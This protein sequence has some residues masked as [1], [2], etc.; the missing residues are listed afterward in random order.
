[1]KKALAI[2]LILAMVLPMCFVVNAAETDVEIKPFYM[3][4][5]LDEFDNIIPKIHFWSDDTE[6]YVTEDGIIV[7]AIGLS[8]KTPKDIAAKLKPV[9]DKY[10]DGLRWIRFSSFR[11]ALL[12]LKEDEIFMEKGAKLIKEWVTEF[13]KEYS[14]IGG[15]LDGISV[16]FEYVDANTYELTKTA[17]TDIYV[18]KKIVENP[19]YA[20]KI[21]PALEE[22]GFKFWPNVTDE[23]PE[24]YSVNNKSGSEYAQSRNIWNVVLRNHYNSYVTE[25]VYEPAKEYYPDIVVYDYQARDTYSWLKTPGNDGGVTAG[26]NYIVAG[27]MNYYNAYGYAPS[28]DFFKEEGQP[29]YKKI[30]SYNNVQWENSAFK[31][32]LWDSILS[33]NYYKT[34]PNNNFVATVTYY[35]YSTREGSYG[36]TAYYTE[37][38][39][40]LGL[41]NPTLFNGYIEEKEV[42]N[43]GNDI[44]ETMEVVHKI[45]NELTRIVGAADRKPLDLPYSWNDAFILSGMYAGGKNYYRLTPD[46]TGGMK[47]EDF[48]VK[49]AK[50]L[51]FTY[52]GQTITFPGGKIIE[53]A[54]IPIVGS[55]GFWIETAKDVLPIITYSENRYSEYPAL[56]EDY[57]SYKV[58]ED[59][60]ITTAFPAGC[61]ELKKDKTGAAKIADDSGNQVLALSGTYSLKLKDILKNITAGDTY[62]ENQA[63]EIDVKVPADMG[64]ES[65]IVLLDVYSSKT[66]A[67]EGGIKIAG[68]KVYYDNAGKYE[69]LTGVD[70]SA[71]GKF[72]FQRSMD[73]NNPEAITCDYSVYDASG[74]LLGQAKDVPVVALSL[75]I[76]RVGLSV[77]KITGEAVQLDNLKLYANGLAADFELYDAKTG[78]EYTD[79]ETAKD[80][81]VAYRLSWMNAT[82]SEKVYSVVAVYGNGE[83]KVI[84]TIKMAPGTDAVAT[85][86][87][88]T[89]GQSVKIYARN[90]SKAD[91][92]GDDDNTGKPGNSGS[93]SD[94][95]LLIAVIAGGVVLLALLVVV[96]VVL[97]KKKPAPAAEEKTDK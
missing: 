21:R 56:M 96:I 38:F 65:E 14:A 95:T 32:T 67:A 5:S 37:D 16:D 93:N 73:F 11:A 89:D 70:V 10:P 57:E 53:D 72:K 27:N 25:A 44:V 42:I 31:M 62:A 7:S 48:L 92:A 78:I 86:I 69:E 35:N 66:K 54:E 63:W 45:L 71:G 50:D 29:I 76:E 6:K 97:T 47:R 51:T 33:K 20:T 80:K 61:W 49:D 87:V 52:Q 75:P 12:T 55:C 1:M 30:P 46:V 79:L 26:G 84:E 24:I 40:H 94:N 74:K 28:N 4:N 91:P 19:N 90:D 60:N 15:K 8:A 43:K 88:E 17:L 34:A 39:Y 2:L 77:T 85:G 59:F 68:G 18:Y 81:S 83:E 64:A 36:N 58:G 82:S 9:F 13:V 41:L 22:R 23:T 3:S